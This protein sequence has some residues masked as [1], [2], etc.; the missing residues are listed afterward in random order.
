MMSSVKSVPQVEGDRNARVALRTIRLPLIPSFTSTI[1]DPGD[2]L[3]ST[4][5][6]VIGFVLLETIGGCVPGQ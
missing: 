5:N 4:E 2:I 6:A 3:D 1:V